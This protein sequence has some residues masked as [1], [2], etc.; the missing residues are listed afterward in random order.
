L[1]LESGRKNCFERHR[2]GEPIGKMMTMGVDRTSLQWKTKGMES[3]RFL[4]IIVSL[5]VVFGLGCKSD[6]AGA[7]QW[8]SCTCPYL[9]DYDDVAKHALDVC[10]PEG[11]KAEQEAY[12][13][14]TKLAHGPAE[15]C[16]CGEPQ[17]PCDGLETCRSK[18]YK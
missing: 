10:V 11:K 13:C 4:W 6:K 18:E 5:A 14:A 12:H 7:G 8:V 1:T 16:R 17:G 9:T 3:L 15:A 2:A